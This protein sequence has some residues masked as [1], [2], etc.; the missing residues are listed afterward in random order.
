MEDQIDHSTHFALPSGGGGFVVYTDASG[1]G[2][3]YV[4]MKNDKVIA[5]DSR[6]LKE[7]E[8]KYDA[9]DLELAAIVLALKM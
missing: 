4:L 5:Y 7:H 1:V 6:Q 8:K 3:G 2:L 9:H